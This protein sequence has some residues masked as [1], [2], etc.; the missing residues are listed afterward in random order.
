VP[1]RF[2]TSA[3]PKLIEIAAGDF[4]LGCP[5][6]KREFPEQWETVT[7]QIPD[8]KAAGFLIERL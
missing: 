7:P 8:C 3:L 4:F 5:E 6:S 2:Q 1:K